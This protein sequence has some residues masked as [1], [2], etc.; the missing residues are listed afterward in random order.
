MLICVKVPT[1][2]QDESQSFCT[3]RNVVHDVGTYTNHV[4]KYSMC[5]FYSGNYFDTPVE[6]ENMF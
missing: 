1:P 2:F 4:I 3:T 6:F 5:L